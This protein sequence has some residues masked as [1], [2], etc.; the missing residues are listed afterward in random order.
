MPEPATAADV[1]EL[2]RREMVE[3]SSFKKKARADAQVGRT[4]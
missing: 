2:Y 1:D 3:D 4:V